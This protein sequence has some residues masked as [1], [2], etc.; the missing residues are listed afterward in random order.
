M[1][2]GDVGTITASRDCMA[3]KRCGGQPNTI[4]HIS[5]L[6][7]KDG[8]Y[9]IR[10]RRTKKCLA[11]NV[12]ETEVEVGSELQKNVRKKITKT[13][14][15]KWRTCYHRQ[16]QKWFVTLRGPKIHLPLAGENSGHPI[17]SS[18]VVITTADPDNEYVR[19]ETLCLTWQRAGLKL[20]K[21]EKVVEGHALQLNYRRLP[22]Q[23]CRISLSDFDLPN[24]PE[25]YI[26]ISFL[27][28]VPARE[29]RY[30][31][32]IYS[33]PCKIQ[34][35]S[36]SHGYIVDQEEGVPFQLPG[37]NITIRC[38]HGFRVNLDRLKYADTYSVTCSKDMK[39][40]KCA[41]KPV[42]TEPPSQPN[43]VTL[44]KYLTKLLITDK[45]QFTKFI[46]ISTICHLSKI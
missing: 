45:L 22:Y 8:G 21:C 38:R 2:R 3:G 26:P 37:E 43:H 16:V 19:G 23:E 12:A 7:K 41:M 30:E 24:N 34:N 15:L 4:D 9:V 33:K 36:I 25:T 18:K 31:D 29:F 17:V 6:S 32:V 28:D 44:V 39:M 40:V 35:S 14:N 42:S 1:V 5:R 13:L 27:A 46:E 11:V 10:N 20:Q